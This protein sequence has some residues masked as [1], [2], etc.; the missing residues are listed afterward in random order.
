MRSDRRFVCIHGHFY[1]PPRENPWLEDIETQDSAYPYHDWNERITAECYAPNTASRILDTDLKIIDI[2]NNYSRMSFNF[3]PTLLSWMKVHSPQIHEAIIEADRMSRTRFS[4]H[5]SAVAQV[6]NHMIM[7]LANGRDRKTQVIWGIRDFQSRFGRSPE[8]MWLAETAADLLTLD[9]L[10]ENGIK[11]TVLAPR[12]AKRV[13]LI[14]TEEWRDVSG[15]KVDTKSVY[16]CQLPSGRKIALFFY[17][18]AIARDIAFGNLLTSGENYAK[19]IMSAFSDADNAGP[20]I[21]HIATDGETY[22][23]HY[24]LADMSLAYCLYDIEAKGQARITVYGE[25]LGKFPPRHE[26]EIFENTSWSCEHGIERWRSDCG[27]NTGVNWKQFWRAPLREAMDWLRD[28]LVPVYEKELGFYVNDPWKVR[29]AYIDVI[30]DRREENVEKFL[31]EKVDPELSA[32]E[33]NRILTLLEMQRHAMLMYTSCGWFFDEVSGLETTQVMSYAARALHLAEKATGVSFENAFQGKL[34]KVPTNI[35]DF[36]NG[37]H[38][39]EIF[40][41]PARLDLYRVGAH[42]AISSLFTEYPEKF[43]IYCYGGVNRAYEQVETGLLSLATGRIQIRSN[44][45]WNQKE[46]SFAVIN[47][48]GYNISGGARDFIGEEAFTRMRGQIKEA[49]LKSDIPGTIRLI[50]RH[51]RSQEYSI[52][53]MFRDE[54]RKILNI[55]M[56]TTLEN[57]EAVFRQIYETNYPVMNMMSALRAPLPKALSTTVEFIVNRDLR[58]ILEKSDIPVSALRKQVDEIRKWP[59]EPDRNSL[60]LIARNSITGRAKR[61]AEDPFDLSLW[62]KIEE[63]IRTLEPLHLDIGLWETQNIYFRIGTKMYAGMQKKAEAGDA[64]AQSWLER[65]QRLGDELK[66][67]FK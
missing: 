28:E 47:L 66:M 36:Q 65:F 7:P 26:V 37:A 3:G 17:D 42:Y 64:R 38:I 20:Q 11:Y 16:S 57:V 22:G 27:C 23:H 50:D 44:L 25:Y 49:F 52:W 33:K 60:N 4:G 13:R 58:D 67:K 34:V 48:G 45:T 43:Q 54:Q 19:R 12:Q 15:E 41:K 1:Q 24:K 40:V 18:G 62:E 6:Y 30:L 21:V 32:E 63:I 39:Y 61:L 35:P 29:D 55:V 14:G 51:F 53:S 9:I 10:A 2:I 31:R 56:A 8:G 59:I 5:G 46:I